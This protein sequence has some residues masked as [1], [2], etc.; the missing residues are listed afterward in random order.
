MDAHS[1]P[2]NPDDFARFLS[3]PKA[4]CP[5]CGNGVAKRG[6]L[7]RSCR[8]QE[9]ADQRENDSGPDGVCWEYQDGELPIRLSF[10]IKVW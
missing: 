2:D 6:Q 10:S 4:L 9:A 1:Y 5:G 8:I 3:T 7:C